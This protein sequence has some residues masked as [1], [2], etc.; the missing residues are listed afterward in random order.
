MAHS[1]QEIF[2]RAD[3]TVAVAGTLKSGASAYEWDEMTNA[4]FAAKV[5]AARAARQVANDKKA[6][7]DAQRGRVNERF[8]ELE[9]RKIQAIGMAKYRF[10]RD[11]RLGEMVESV[12]EYGEGRESTLREAEEWLAAWK[13]IDPQWNPTP[14][15]TLAGFET[16][17]ADCGAQLG[18]LTQL[19]SDARKAGIDLSALL[20]EIEEGCVSWYGVATRAF[21][22]GTSEGD[23]LRSQI[24]TFENG[25]AAEKPAIAPVAPT[26]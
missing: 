9:A 18:I 7:Y 17:L 2:E 22:V 25:G 8:D 12:G 1:E 6:D 26:A 5:A 16:L 11:A 13:N 14:G 23:L 21:P 19:K 4:A 15:N 3:A 20:A 24:P 10:R